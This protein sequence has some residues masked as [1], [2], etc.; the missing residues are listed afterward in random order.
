MPLMTRMH[1]AESQ[2]RSRRLLSL[3]AFR[4]LVIALMVL[5]NS[6]GRP[7]TW[8]ILKHATWDGCSLADCVFPFF[9]VILGMSSVLAISSALERGVSQSALYLAIIWRAFYLFMA[10]LLLNAFPHHLSDFAVRMPGVLQRIALCYLASALLVMKTSAR[11]QLIL[12]VLI[13]AGYWLLYRHV[14]GGDAI[15]WIGG[16][17]RA[18]FGASHLYR[19][20][21]DPEGLL[22]TLPAF[23]SVLLGNLAGYQLKRT[24]NV[25]ENLLF[26]TGF[27]LLLMFGGW[28]L[29]FT[30]PLNKSLW[31]SSYVL[32]TAG[33]S[34]LVYAVCYALIEGCGMRRGAYPFILM[35]RH[36]LLIYLLH[37]FFLKLQQMVLI[38][39][40]DGSEVSFRR[41]VTDTLFGALSPEKAS[42]GYALIYMLLWL[43]FAFC[44]EHLSYKKSRPS[45]KPHL[46]PKNLIDDSP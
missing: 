5:V 12:A 39:M 18:I 1:E 10:G 6:P 38:R 24:Q 4:G 23:A 26:F 7:E 17:D 13:L 31:S 14:P 35:G 9:V 21:F 32:M 27:S 34:Y 25:A 33:L 41:F 11:T 19:P 28:V 37:V 2:A 29:S 43:L 46:Q 44:S 15:A 36:A 8:N 40:P 16:I 20:D 22:T 30:F 45:L 42:F 3:D